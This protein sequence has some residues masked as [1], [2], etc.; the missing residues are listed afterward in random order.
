VVHLKLLL[1]NSNLTKFKSFE[2][3][4]FMKKLV[5]VLG[6]LF[7][8]G[9]T[10]YAQITPTPANSKAFEVRIGNGITDS[11]VT[12]PAAVYIVFKDVPTELAA[13]DILC[14]IGNFASL[15]RPQGETAP[16]LAAAKRAF[17]LGEI[18]AV[19]RQKIEA[20]RLKTAQS[21][22]IPPDVSDLP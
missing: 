10:A 3:G 18:K 19:I 11:A 12:I 13:V 9:R 2:K 4:D 6:L 15:P 7:V 16:Q 8:F 20:G 21:V 17:A 22:V 14:D 1:F 5:M